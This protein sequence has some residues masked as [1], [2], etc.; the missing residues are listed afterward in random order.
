LLPFGMRGANHFPRADP[1]PCDKRG[2]D[3]RGRAERKLVSAECL[4]ESV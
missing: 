3:H 2:N 1:N 4:S